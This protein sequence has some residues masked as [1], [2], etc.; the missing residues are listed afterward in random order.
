MSVAKGRIPVEMRRWKSGIGAVSEF[1]GGEG[2]GSLSW[3]GMYVREGLG[4]RLVC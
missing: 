2:G 1:R 4:R 3:R